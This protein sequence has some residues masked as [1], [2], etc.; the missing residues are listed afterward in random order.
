MS[1]VD[2]RCPA[3]G[4]INKSV[5]LEETDGWMECESCG[6]VTQQMKYVT[7][8]RVPRY[9]MNE[10]RRK[11]AFS[12]SVTALHPYIRTVRSSPPSFLLPN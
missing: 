2:A 9:E 1:A 3:C 6:E 7:T 11:E 5:D 10:V 4:T 12:F 8:R